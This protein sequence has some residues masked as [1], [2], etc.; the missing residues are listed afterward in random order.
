MPATAQTLMPVNGSVFDEPP[1]PDAMVAVG[2]SEVELGAVAEGDD[3]TGVEVDGAGALDVDGDV[4]EL[5]GAG[6][7]LAGVLLAGCVWVCEG[8]VVPA[9]GSVYCW[10]PAEPPPPWASATAGAD[11]S[12]ST[13]KHARTRRDRIGRVLQALPR[14]AAGPK[15]RPSP[16]PGQ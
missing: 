8:L 7:V 16:A 2:A 6:V 15:S 11:R 4:L 1:A 5:D 13:A 12:A 10:S 14:H 9:S 3:V